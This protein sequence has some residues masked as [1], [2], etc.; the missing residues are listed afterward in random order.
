MVPPAVLFFLLP[1]EI[2]G[3]LVLQPE[4]T[5]ATT[6]NVGGQ[7]AGSTTKKIEMVV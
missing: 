3:S 6:Q 5:S 1:T 4:A 2:I 7:N